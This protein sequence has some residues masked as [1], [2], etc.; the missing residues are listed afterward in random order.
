MTTK[1]QYIDKHAYP[2]AWLFAFV[3]R[4]MTALIVYIFIIISDIHYSLPN[5]IEIGQLAVKFSLDVSI[6]DF[7]VIFG[8]ISIEVTCWWLLIRLFA[9]IVNYLT[10]DSTR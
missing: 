4:I 7:L 8:W 3:W 9:R 6:F 1:I 10:N 2:I 5:T